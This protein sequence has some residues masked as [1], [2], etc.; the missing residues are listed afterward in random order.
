M[1]AGGARSPGAELV[2]TMQFFICV[3]CLVCL[4]LLEAAFIHFMPHM[5]VSPGVCRLV[6]RRLVFFFSI[7]L[8]QFFFLSL[9]LSFSLFLL[10]CS[11]LSILPWHGHAG[12]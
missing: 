12:P 5:F 7:S 10:Y 11:L 3:F 9:S 6:V 8:S 1:S 4:L 2:L